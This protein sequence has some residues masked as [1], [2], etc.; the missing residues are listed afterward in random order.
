MTIFTGSAQNPIKKF[1]KD[2]FD[3]QEYLPYAKNKSY[4]KK[5]EQ[6]LLTALS[7]YPELKGVRIIFRYKKT[8]TPLTS[9]PRILHIFKRRKRRTYIITLSSETTTSYAPI[10]FDNLP[11]NAQIGVLGHELGHIAYYINANSFKIIGLGFGLLNSK[12]V[13]TFE[14]NTD[15][16]TIEHGLG[17]QLYDWSVFVRKALGITAW[18]G[19]YKEKEQNTERYMNPETILKIMEKHPLYN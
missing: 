3:I 1:D 12:K 4:P 7:F 19:T 2:I 5:I 15:K 9:R 18:K 17:Y 14:Y 11:Y 10:L 16:A 6:Q 8:K 13:D